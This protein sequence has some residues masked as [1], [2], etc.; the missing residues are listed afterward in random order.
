MK[1]RGFGLQ[2][3]RRLRLIARR[4]EPGGIRLNRFEKNLVKADMNQLESS[5]KA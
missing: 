1:P 3:L 5:S 2:S 4:L